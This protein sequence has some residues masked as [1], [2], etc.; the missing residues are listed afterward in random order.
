MFLRQKWLKKSQT[1][2]DYCLFFS[3][4]VP[5]LVGTHFRARVH[6]AGITKIRDY[7]EST[8]FWFWFWFWFRLDWPWTVGV[9]SLDCA[10]WRTRSLK[11]PNFILQNAEKQEVLTTPKNWKGTL[12]HRV[13]FW[14]N[15]EFDPQTQSLRTSGLIWA[16]SLRYFP[17]HKFCYFVS[18][19]AVFNF[20]RFTR[21]QSEKA[22]RKNGQN[23]RLGHGGILN[24]T[25]QLQYKDRIYTWPDIT[26][27]MQCNRT[28][29]TH[30]SRDVSHDD[31]VMWR[32]PLFERDCSYVSGGG[33][34]GL[35][36]QE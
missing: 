11:Q 33:G 25:S 2:R 36:W 16:I 10:T 30:W 8:G 13:S 18:L 4:S 29:K 35:A 20:H 19:T 32:E 24:T 15:L 23:N 34:G 26:Q 21:N 5:P 9:P 7:S 17:K 1:F 14:L 28:V 6:Y 3:V 12:N 22:N 27:C 31:S